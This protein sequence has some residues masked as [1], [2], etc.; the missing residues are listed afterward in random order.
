MAGL[1][2]SGRT[3]IVTGAAKG[4]GESYARWLADHG[5]AVVVSNRP[6]ADGSSQAQAVVE[7]ILSRGGRAAA[8]DGP[9]ETADAAQEM[10][11]VAKRH[12]G[13]VDIF[14]SN[15]GIVRFIDFSTVSIDEMRE[16]IDINM[17]GAVY[18]LKAVWPSMLERG[19]GRAVLT[20]SSAG[21]WG[22]PQSASYSM[23]KAAMV[24]L[25]R[26]VSLDIPEGKDIKVNVIC[27]AAYTP[28]SAGHMGE[29]WADY[30]SSDRVAPVVGWLCSDKCNVTG[31]IYHSGASNVRRVQTLESPVED[32]ESAP[33]EEVMARLTAKP[34]WTSS[35]ASGAEVLP[36]LVKAL[37]AE[38]KSLDKH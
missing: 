28:M 25:A 27:P 38:A 35:Y 23:S 17:W 36:D 32:V 34:E 22:Q 3:A 16:V 15:A 21:L 12:F 31:A 13:G 4:L 2:F 1:D 9:V 26:S 18:G 14:V 19:Y 29:K 24:G 11:E 7:G 30:A 10:V 6:A 37:Q 20:G 5:C 8:H 33:I